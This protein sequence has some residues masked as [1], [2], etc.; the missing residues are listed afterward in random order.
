MAFVQKMQSAIDQGPNEDHTQLMP[1]YDASRAKTYVGLDVNNIRMKCH[2]SKVSPADTITFVN[3]ISNAL[4]IDTPLPIVAFNLDGKMN[5][6]DASGRKLHLNE[7]FD[8]GKK[9][10]AVLAL[11]PDSVPKHRVLADKFN[12]LDLFFQR[13]AFDNFDQMFPKANKPS[14]FGKFQT[15]FDYKSP[16]TQGS[17]DRMFLKLHLKTQVQYGLT[18]LATYTD[19]VDGEEIITEVMDPGN[20]LR[21]G[22]TIKPKVSIKVIWTRQG[23]MYGPKYA[24]SSALII[25]DADHGP[26]ADDE[27]DITAW[28]APDHEESTSKITDEGNTLT[29]TKKPKKKRTSSNASDLSDGE[30]ATSSSSKKFKRTAKSPLPLGHQVTEVL[31]DSQF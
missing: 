12:E 26:I 14:T 3:G 15:Q 29:V 21:V 5:N 27:D 18:R 17:N 1:V 9:A 23:N 28:T 10:V 30:V 31:H 20:N 13:Q 11:T 6:T 8:Q 24:M 4:L 19:T 7:M 2:R 16:L 25:K 22:M